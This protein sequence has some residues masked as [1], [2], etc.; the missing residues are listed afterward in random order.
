MN[1]SILHSKTT[2]QLIRQNSVSILGHEQAIT[3]G[4]PNNHKKFVFG[5]I[6]SLSGVFGRICIFITGFTK[7]FG[8]I[9]FL[10]CNFGKIW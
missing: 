8:N 6:W 3:F 2:L 10:Q 4:V 9:W 7:K 1:Q 5:V